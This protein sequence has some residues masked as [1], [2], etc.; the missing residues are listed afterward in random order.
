MV[1]IKLEPENPKRPILDRRFDNSL[2]MWLLSGVFPE[3]PGRLVRASTVFEG[4]SPSK[5]GMAGSFLG[6]IVTRHTSAVCG[7]SFVCG[8]EREILKC[9]P[10]D[11]CSGLIYVFRHLARI[12]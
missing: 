11:V 12:L 1:S 4:Q 10:G 7:P 6:K 3:G 2:Y 8:L 9:L 5:E